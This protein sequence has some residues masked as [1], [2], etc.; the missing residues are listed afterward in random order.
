M[1]R[2][3]LERP[4]VAAGWSGERERACSKWERAVCGV[5]SERERWAFW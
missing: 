3:R 2:R 4:M 5:E 1:S